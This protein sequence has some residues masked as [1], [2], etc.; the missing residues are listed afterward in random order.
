MFKIIGKNMC[1]SNFIVNSI[2]ITAV[3][4]V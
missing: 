2:L 3:I 4:Y 1:G